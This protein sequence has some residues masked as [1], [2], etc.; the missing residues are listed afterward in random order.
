MIL[1]R[2]KNRRRG[3][4]LIELALSTVLVGVLITAALRATGQSLLAQVKMADRARGE[5]LARSLLSEILQ[6]AYLEPNS[7]NPPLGID[8]SETAGLRPSYDDVDDYHGHSESPPADAAGAAI[9]AYAGWTRSVAVTLIDPVTLA[10][11]TGADTG[12]KRI[13]VTAS[14]NGSPV[15]TAVGY[16]TAAP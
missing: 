9:A 12:A 13:T 4:T 8:V 3:N 11:V 10:P 14:L 7:T 5:L 6:K 2:S 1:Q 16:R 15:A